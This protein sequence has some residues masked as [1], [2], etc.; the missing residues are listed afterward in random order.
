[1]SKPKGV[2]LIMRA[3]NVDRSV[4]GAA[5]LEKKLLEMKFSVA[6]LGKSSVPRK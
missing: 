4:R 2:V 6:Y 5:G 3:E 1:M